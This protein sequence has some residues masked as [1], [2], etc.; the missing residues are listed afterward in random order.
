[1]VAVF[2][3]HVAGGE[4]V[5]EE[6]DLFVGNAVGDF[7]GTDV[8]E[9]NAGE[10]CLSAGVAAEHVGV[11]EEAGGRVAHDLFGDPG[12]G[13]GVVATGPELILAELTV[14]AGDGEGNDDAVADLEFVAVDAWA[15]LDNLTHEFVAE[16]IALLHGGYKAVIEVKVGA[17]DACGGDADDGI[18]RVED[19]GI[20]NV[21][22][23]HLLFA[24]P[25]DSFHRFAPCAEGCFHAVRASPACGCGWL[26]VSRK[27]TCSVWPWTPRGPWVWPTVVGTSPVSRRDLKRR[28]SSRTTNSGC[29]PKMVATPVP[30][31][32]PG[33]RYCISAVM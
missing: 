28:R 4:D 30:S 9:G 29:L 3:G 2:G 10:L 20:R 19:C 31:A 27:S 12:V 17:A 6:D 11:T 15:D 21:V 7:D 5:G 13:V 23:L 25:A 22:N 33:R 8:G 18:A 1:D 26:V 16:D 24:H 14:A 32:P